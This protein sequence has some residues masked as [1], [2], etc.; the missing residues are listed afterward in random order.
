[1]LAYVLRFGARILTRRVEAELWPVVL[2]IGYHVQP[3]AAVVES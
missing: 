1:M 2:A 3:R